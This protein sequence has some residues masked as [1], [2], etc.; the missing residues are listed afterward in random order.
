MLSPC[1]IWE[2]R[3]VVAVRQTSEQRT[4]MK[5][6]L[7]PAHRLAR[8]NYAPRA[9]A[10]ALIFLA[11]CALFAE[12]GFAAWELVFAA[13]S[14]LAYPHLAYLHA[15]IAPDSKRAELSNL[16]LDSI[17]MGIW[18][19]QIHFALWPTVTVMTAIILNNAANGGVRQLLW[20]GACVAVAIAAWGAGFGYRFDPHTGALVTGISVLGIFAYV[21]WVGT[22]LF[23]QNKVLLR[24]HHQLQDSERQFHS[25]CRRKP[26]RAGFRAGQTGLH[27]LREFLARNALRA[28]RARRGIDLA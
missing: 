10:F 15:R 17:L 28:Q 1:L 27:T 4:R 20:G 16:Y 7:P 13:L 24:T 3:G 11:L 21:S 19:T 9:G 23:V 25:L 6:S 2:G 22:I 18:V 26:R 12:R 8:I 5:I 14:F